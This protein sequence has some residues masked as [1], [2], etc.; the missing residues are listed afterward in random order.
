VGG[1][2]NMSR[3]RKGTGVRPRNGNIEVSFQFQG[4]RCAERINLKPTPPNLKHAVRLRAEIV[5]KIESG[6]FDYAEYFPS[7]TRAKVSAVLSIDE[8][9]FQRIASSM[10]QVYGENHHESTRRGYETAL[11]KYWLPCFADRDIRDLDIETVALEVSAIDWDRLGSSTRNNYLIALR[12]VF[13]YALETGKI[14]TDP[15][16]MIKN[17]K[18]TPRRADPLGLDEVDKL[19][20]FLRESRRDEIGNYIEFAIWTG[21]RPEEQI[22][23]KWEDIDFRHATM[24][25]ERAFALGKVKDTK[26]GG[27][28]DVELNQMALSALQRQKASTFLAGQYVFVTPT[29]ERYQTHKVIAEKSWKWALKRLGMRYRNFYQCRHTYATLNL[30]AG[31]NIAWIAKQLGNSPEV[32]SRV[33]AKWIDGADRSREN[34]KLAQF[35][36]QS[37]D[38]DAPICDVIATFGGVVDDEANEINN[39]IGRRNWIRTNK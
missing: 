39:L 5:A 22:E 35:L 18:P 37:R 34:N 14:K 31:A 7:S 10:M 8:Y 20:G 13:S 4:T 24:R 11:R 36:A 15:T 38:A 29:G 9:L 16:A 27:V 21:L 26:T 17:R 33:Y 25:I 3:G 19:V 32:C 23:L 2:K 30:M 12:A 28:R 6:T 1:E